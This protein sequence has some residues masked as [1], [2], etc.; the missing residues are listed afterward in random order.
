[1]SNNAE[2]K[3]QLIFLHFEGFP[4]ERKL[5]NNFCLKKETMGHGAK[6]RTK[7]GKSKH[8]RVAGYRGEMVYQCVERQ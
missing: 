1:M 3:N 8:P 2:T 5:N 7:I 4:S 6:I